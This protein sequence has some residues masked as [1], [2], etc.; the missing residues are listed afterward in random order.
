MLSALQ[1]DLGGADFEVLTIA[2][3]RNAPPAMKKF[4]TDIGATN[5]PMH[6]DSRQALARSM[7]VLGLP[8]TVLIDG[9]GR[10]VAR[11]TGDADWSSDSAT[12]IVR[13]VIDSTLD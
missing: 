13:A 8:V 9:Q 12:R 7:G 10:E 11:L 1:S 5:L 2:T 4:L 3:G 6:T